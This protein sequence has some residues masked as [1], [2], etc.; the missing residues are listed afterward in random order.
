MTVPVRSKHQFEES[1][2]TAGKQDFK[3]QKQTR[4]KKYL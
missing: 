1:A 3:Q 2:L 4:K